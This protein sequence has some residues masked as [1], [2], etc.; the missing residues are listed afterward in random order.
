[1]ADLLRARTGLNSLAG[2]V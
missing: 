2:R 1:M